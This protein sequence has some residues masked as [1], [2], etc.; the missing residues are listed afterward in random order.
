MIARIGILLLAAS[1]AGAQGVTVRGV[2]YDSL[3]AK[4]LVGAFVSLA[5]R[6]ATSDDKGR[7]HFDSIAPGQYRLAMQHDALDSTGMSGIARQVTITDGNDELR[8][9][10]PSFNTLW[11]AACYSSV[12]PADSGLLFG[13]VRLASGTMPASV[14]V[15]ASWVDVGFEKKSGVT[16]KR[17]RIEAPIDSSG[18]YTLCGVPLNTGL[19]LFTLFDST[20]SGGFVDL[21]PLD[22]SRVT[23]TDLTLN[24]APVDT[25]RA[26]T[27]IGTVNV[28]GDGVRDARV[29]AE[30][31]AEVRTDSAGQ[32]TIRGVP[33]GIQQVEV[34]AIGHQ[35]VY[36]TVEVRG[37]DTVRMIVNLSKVT[38]LDSMVTK[39]SKVREQM[40]EDIAFR[41][42]QGFGLFRDSTDVEKH[43]NMTALFREVPGAHFSPTCKA[44]SCPVNFLV[45]GATGALGFQC[46]AS[47]WIDGNYQQDQSVMLNMDPVQI[48]AIEIYPHVTTTPVEFTSRA[49]RNGDCGT[50][51]LWTKRLTRKK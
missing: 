42:K 1:L 24:L 6:S 37:N 12:A 47:L 7:F 5:T 3:H 9:A 45:P 35:P 25:A 36:K 41:K 40:I 27:I 21:L 13:T 46:E 51:V 32:F 10:V 30:G 22:K 19:R 16:Q 31:S 39:G 28:E 20:R 33:A 2:A 34:R 4:P 49:K 26:G 43:T 44:F 29:T 23:R 14:K 18:N 11:R 15:N 8:I 50:I 48:A 38:M 17:W